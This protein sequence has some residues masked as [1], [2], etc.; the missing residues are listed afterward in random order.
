[1][2]SGSEEIP[3]QPWRLLT[4][5]LHQSEGE[6]QSDVLLWYIL[7]SHVLPQDPGHL[8]GEVVLPLLQEKEKKISRGK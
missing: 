8:T 7:Q 5:S 4:H 2:Q 6:G 3:Q 1:M